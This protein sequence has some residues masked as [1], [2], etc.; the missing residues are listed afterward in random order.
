MK[1]ILL[2][3]LWLY[4]PLSV[5][6][7]QSPVENELLQPIF[8]T[9]VDEKGFS[10]EDFQQ[11]RLADEVFSQKS[12][13][14]HWYIQ[15]QYNG[16]DIHNAVLNATFDGQELKL[17]GNR[18]I[19]RLANRIKQTAPTLGMSDALSHALEA[20]DIENKTISS[21]DWKP[22]LPGNKWM[23]NLP[24]ISAEPI[25]ATLK[26]LLV[27]DVVALTWEISIL[28][29]D[30]H[31]WW[32]LRLDATTGA[33]LDRNDWVIHCDFGHAHTSHGAKPYEVEAMAAAPLPMLPAQYRVF[34]LPVE[35]PNHGNRS[36]LVNPSDST[37][38]PFGWHDV[39]GINGAEYT[40][41]RG[42]NV[43]AYEDA[44]NSNT[45]GFSPDGTSSL[46]FDFPYS[47]SNSV[48]ANQSAAI[49]NLF[50][51]NNMM[52]DIWYHYGFDEAA[53]NFQENNYARGGLAGDYVLAEAQDG[54]GTSNANFA[55]PPDGSNPRMQMYLWGSSSSSSALTVNTPVSISGT[56][57]TGEASFGPGLPATPLTADVILAVDNTAPVNDG[58]EPLV[59]AAAI[60]G[61]IALIDR[62]NCSFVLKVEEAQAAGAV[63]AIIVNNVPGAP[64]TMGG[65]SAI[66]NIPSVMVSQADG[67]L[68]K[69]ALQNGAVN[70]TL[71]SSAGSLIAPDGDFDNGII[72]HEYGHGI[73]IRISG[74]PSNS[75][76]LDN[77]EQMGEGWSDW[78]GLMLTMEP[79]DQGSD[80]RGIGTYA[81]NQS[82]TGVGIRPA[83]Y[84]TNFNVNSYTYGASN[85]ASISVPHGIGFIFATVLWDLNWALINQ[86]GGTHDPDLINGTGGNNIAMQLVIEALKLQPCNPGM[87]DGRDAILAADQ[88]L[89]GGI[90]QC[91]IWDV[92]AN[93][94]LGFSADQG[95]SGNRFDQV[96][97]FDLPPSC[98]IPTA[99][100]T[101]A[102]SS[103]PVSNC[104]LEFVFTDNSTDVPQ[105]W[106]WD[107]GDG[108]TSN[109]QNPSHTY[110]AAG[111]Y[112]VKLVV[113]NTVGSDSAVQTVTINLPSA[114]LVTD[115]QACL[116][117]S[118]LLVGSSQGIIQWSDPNG[119]LGT[120]DSLLLPAI[121]SSQTIYVQSDV[122]PPAQFV[123][124]AN[125][126]IGAGTYHGTGFHGAL[127]FTASQA[128][129]IV[130]AWVDADGPG[131]RTFILATGSGNGSTPVGSS[132]VAQ[133]N[134][135][136]QDGPQRVTLN[137]S[138]PGPGNYHIGAT[139]NTNNALYRNSSGANYPYSIAG[140]IDIT[141]SSATTNPNAYY[142]YLYDLEVQ[143]KQ[144]LSE[145][146][147]LT[148]TP[149]T[150]DFTFTNAGTVYT[151]QDQSI[152]A[153]SWFWDFGD[154]NTSTLQNPVHTYGTS[155]NYT[156]SLAI[157]QG[158]CTA[159]ET[160]AVGLSEVE[161]VW[162]N[163]VVL[164]PNPS[165]GITHLEFASA[166]V[167]A[168]DLVVYAMNGQEVWRT[169]IPN[170]T[171][172]VIIATKQWEAGVYMVH[173]Q[174]Q[175][176]RLVLRLLVK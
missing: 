38:S 36:L 99:P 1:K 113:S 46:V 136:L 86:Y 35:S 79:G 104:D 120:G 126:S 80:V 140:L 132:V 18:M 96:E 71:S 109:S 125:S 66:V 88:A 163:D 81:V 149:G 31:H 107:F 108:N 51:M 101:A 3:A 128:C 134:V 119:I 84:S 91:L 13:L 124:P 53:G 154:G 98:M 127:N 63:A 94:G 111:T 133:Q 7:A 141:S 106:F 52:H 147:T 118:V 17:R 6:Y 69:N 100:P 9:L 176:N 70:A 90:H 67:A 174:S 82:T 114:P 22:S 93:R 157:N 77:A 167:E 144:C 173:L 58:C 160:I 112:I 158:S 103:N 130:S 122:T 150:A 43:Y 75:N 27:E 34:P 32:A 73:S 151:F 10:A 74:G 5:A 24:E 56:Y 123:G 21:I 105:N 14:T 78:F 156:V 110:V 45:P 40:I 115:I 15:Q 142:Y 2:L 48:L 83:P 54:G 11:Y 168:S 175:S 170:G 116:G 68:I 60:N 172:E 121:A 139:P 171:Q 161:N 16:I 135:L 42:N 138:V 97:A 64:I 62:G 39:N 29:Q 162:G 143:E 19:P 4:T 169:R 102:F 117:D 165:E 23:A 59:N 155:G 37:S 164:R 26:Y 55:T 137:L 41:T 28:T 49:T 87:V 33:L 145:A 30:G 65:F 92:F 146:D 61:K 12:G 50:Y 166:N 76:C 57:I 129:E 47:V 152:S 8:K 20:L 72:A 153:N 148:L 85:N 44:N 89:Y 25:V 95:N 131:I 159:E